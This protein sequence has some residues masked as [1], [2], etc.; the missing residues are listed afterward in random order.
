MLPNS[1]NR[2]GNPNYGTD[3]HHSPPVIPGCMT[4]QNASLHRVIKNAIASS[5]IR[6]D[7]LPYA[8]RWQIPAI[9]Y[10]QAQPRIDEL[11]RLSPNGNSHHIKVIIVS[12]DRMLQ[13]LGDRSG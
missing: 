2:M 4:P 8:V 3:Q 1:Q 13:P 12:P 5:Q 11:Y 9:K 6:I 10:P 7:T